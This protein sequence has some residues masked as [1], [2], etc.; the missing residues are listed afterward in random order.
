M[1]ALL[2]QAHPVPAAGDPAPEPAPWDEQVCCDLGRQPLPP[3]AMAGLA[4]V[5]HLAGLAHADPAAGLREADYQRVNRDGTAALLAAA[6][7]AGVAR[8]LYL[9]SVKAVG[10]PGG[11]C[12]DE[13]FTAAPSD[14][15][16]RSK[17]AAEALVL[18]SDGPGQALA[19]RVVLRPALVYGP[20]VKG[21]LASL[22]GAARR[23]VCLPLPEFGNRRSLIGRDDLIAAAWLALHHPRAAGRVYIVSDGVDYSTREIIAALCRAAGRRPP[24]WALPAWLLRAGA[25]LGDGLGALLGRPM[26]LRSAVYWRLA[27]DACYRNHRLCTELDWRPRETLDQGAAAMLAA[28]SP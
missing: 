19:H 20:G 23:G 14:A 3:G 24:G 5:L 16:G 25:R 17:R 9:S 26:P 18:A 8:F 6:G 13:T 22:I 7:A 11:R 27:G 10:D 12:V 15:Y 1:R 2:R 4:G 28:S 21:N